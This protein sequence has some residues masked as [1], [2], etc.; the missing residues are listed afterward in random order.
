MKFIDMLDTDT[1]ALVKLLVNAETSELAD[2][3]KTYT[4]ILQNIKKVFTLFPNIV[5]IATQ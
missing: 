3:S 4:T 5:D 1:V 2:I